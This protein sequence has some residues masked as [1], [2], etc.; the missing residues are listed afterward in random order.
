MEVRCTFEKF[1]YSEDGKRMFVRN[2]HIRL[3]SMTSYPGRPHVNIKSSSFNSV[4]HYHGALSLQMESIAWSSWNGCVQLFTQNIGIL[5]NIDRYPSKHIYFTAIL[6]SSVSRRCPWTLAHCVASWEHYTNVWEILAVWTGSHLS[7]LLI[8]LRTS[9]S[10]SIYIAIFQLSGA[11]EESIPLLRVCY[12]YQQ[13]N[14]S[15]L[16]S[17]LLTQRT[18]ASV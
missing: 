2:G 15:T 14:A 13:D 11:R 12:A 9:A 4:A 7:R 17:L 10:I 1:Q 5:R 18:M 16:S 8:Y 6:I 3:L